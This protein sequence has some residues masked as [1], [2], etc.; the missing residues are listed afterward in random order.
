VKC[1][2]VAS[3]EEVDVADLTAGAG[4]EHCVVD[5]RGERDRLV[6]QRQSLLVDAPHAVDHGRPERHER[7]GE[8]RGFAYGSGR[9]DGAAQ[10]RDAGVGC[11]GVDGGGSGFELCDDRAPTRHATVASRWCGDGCPQLVGRFDTELVTQTCGRPFCDRP[12]LGDVTGRT[13]TS[14]EQCG[15]VLIQRRGFRDL[16]RERHRGVGIAAT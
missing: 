9:H 2:V 5:G 4:R 11:A 14:D 16:A 7:S 6:Q 15:G 10:C 13:Q 12:G 3:A 1:P 8:Q